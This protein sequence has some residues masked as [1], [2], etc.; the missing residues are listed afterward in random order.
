MKSDWFKENKEAHKRKF[1]P[2]KPSFMCHTTTKDGLKILVDGRG[3]TLYV[4][5][6]EEEYEQKAQA[7]I[8]ILRI[9]CRRMED[10]YLSHIRW[11]PE[12]YRPTYEEANWIH[13]AYMRGF[14]LIMG[15]TDFY[16]NWFGLSLYWPDAKFKRGNK[17]IHMSLNGTT[18]YYPEDPDIIEAIRKVEPK[19]LGFFINDEPVYENWFGNLPS[20]EF[21][22]D[23]IREEQNNI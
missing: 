5:K 7:M 20:Q 6:D 4:F 10:E 1:Y 13:K 9:Q 17:L 23:F 18:F 22:E 2:D 21:I 8:N 16:N 11:H 15:S 19:Y 12:Y 3:K 14:E